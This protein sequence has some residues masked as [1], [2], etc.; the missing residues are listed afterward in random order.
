MERREL[1]LAGLDCANCA[2]TIE[3]EV[4]RLPGSGPP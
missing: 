2:L 1:K 3:K 4:N